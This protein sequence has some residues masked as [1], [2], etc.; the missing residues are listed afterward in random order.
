MLFRGIIAPASLKQCQRQPE[1]LPVGLFRGIIAPASLKRAF[2]R[3]RRFPCQL[4]IADHP[5]D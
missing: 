4:E 5:Q 2:R 3:S 1:V